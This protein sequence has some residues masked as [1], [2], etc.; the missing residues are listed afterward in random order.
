[1]PA[2]RLQ[3]CHDRACPFV[4]QFN[5]AFGL[6]LTGGIGLYG[7]LSFVELNWDIMEPI[8]YITGTGISLIGALCPPSDACTCSCALVAVHEVF[9]MCAVFC[10]RCFR[11]L[12]L[13][14]NCV[15][16]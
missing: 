13:A 12:V 4:H 7:Y 16:V 2:C 9:R 8:T 1:V 6:G 10:V 3:R 5:A 11:L 15:R 14:G